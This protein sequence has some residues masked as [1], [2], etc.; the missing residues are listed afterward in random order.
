MT[1]TGAIV[2]FA[3]IWFMCLFV[4]LPQKVRSQEE[5]GDV[6]PGTPASAPSEPMM[7]KKF[8]W[9]TV[10]TVILWIIVMTVIITGAIDIADI[11]FSGL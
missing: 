2:L 4:I 11:D 1:I 8:I 7:R 6:A 10:A 9:T 3:V 5:A